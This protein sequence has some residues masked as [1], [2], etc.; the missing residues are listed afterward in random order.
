[1]IKREGLISE[2]QINTNIIYHLTGIGTGVI[3]TKGEIC[4][5]IY[6]IS[7]PFQVVDNDFPIKETGLLGVSFLQKQKAILKFKENFPNIIEFEKYPLIHTFS[8]HDLPPRTKVLISVPTNSTRDSGYV[9]RINTGPDIFLG[10]VLASQ[11]NGYVKLYT[12]NTSFDHVKLTIPPVDLEEF[13]S[14]PP[15]PRS[16]RTGNPNINASK[17]CAKRFAELLKT[18]KL[19]HLNEKE[20]ISILKIICKFPYQFFHP[21]DKLK[22]AKVT[23]HT[24]ITTDDI[25]I[26]TKQYRYPLIHK[27]EIETQINKLLDNNIIQPSVSPYNSPLWIVPKKSDSSGKPRWRMVIDYRKLNEKTVADAY[28]L[29]NIIEILDQLGGAK[30]FSTLDL[31]SGFHQIPM[32]PVSKFKTAFSTPHGHFEFNRMPF[33]L[34]NAPATFQRTMDM[35]LTGLQGIEL[36]I[37]MDD[38]VIY[39]KSLEEHAEKLKTLLA[40][41]QTSG[42]TLQPDKCRFLQKE[43]VYLGHVISEKGVTPDPFLWTSDVQSSFEILRDI[44]CAEPLL[45]FPDFSQPFLVTTDASDFAV[46]AILSQGVIGKDLPIA[47][48]SRTLNDTGRVN[49]NVDALSRNP[50][51][52]K[53]CPESKLRIIKSNAD[54]NS[55]Y[56]CQEEVL[57]CADESPVAD[58]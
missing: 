18:M 48:A 38:I 29:P 39:A 1:M 12:I 9:R 52:S 2:E 43:V 11:Q 53:L 49:A 33:G 22:S 16:S 55:G 27:K 8:T 51:K 23:P 31:A 41:L 4:L 14:V 3:L 28:P 34:K 35:V 45:Q 44:I 58:Y 7:I 25:P 19:D 50:I 42:L 46:G 30:Y 54:S 13:E 21:S 17:D 37:Y 24:I 32:D 57:V 15:A 36:F 10:E 5:I 6:E 47:Y 56:G 40:R 20:K 26:N